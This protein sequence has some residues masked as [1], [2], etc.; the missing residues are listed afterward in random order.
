MTERRLVAESTLAAGEVL[1]ARGDKRACR[2][3]L[4]GTSCRAAVTVPMDAVAE[5]IRGSGGGRDVTVSRVRSEGGCWGG[6]G[7]EMRMMV[8]VRMRRWRRWRTRREGKG[9]K[10]RRNITR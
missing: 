2:A 8:M 7:G 6:R 4:A 1:I 3:A 10:N 9:S 5:E